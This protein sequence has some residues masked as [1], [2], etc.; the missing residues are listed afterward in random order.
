MPSY[1]NPGIYVTE[2]PFATNVST[3]PSTAAAAF[4]GT[5][6][7]GPTTPTLV[8]SWNSYKTMFGDLSANYELGYA[9]YHFFANGGRTAFVSRVASSAA[10][11]GFASFAGATGGSST[12]SL[13]KL[14]AN[15]AGAWGNKLK[16]SVSE[17]SVTSAESLT[18]TFNIV[19]KYNDTEVERWSELS[20]NKDDSRH[21]EAVINNY[22]S[23]I[24]SYDVNPSAAGASY[25][26][27]TVTD[28]ALTGGNDGNALTTSDWE[29]ALSGLD[30]VEGQ[31]TINLPGQYTPAIINKAIEYVDPSV[32]GVARKNSF[33]IIDPNPTKVSAEE[34]LSFVSGYTVS[35][36]AAVYYGMLLMSNPAVRGS[37]ALRSTFPGGAVAGLY[38]RVDTEK[39]VGR[40]PAGYSYTIQNAF[41]VITQFTEAQVGS[42]Y[43]PTSGPNVNTFK[44]VPGA[45]VIINGARTMKRTDITKY[46]PA[47]RTLNSIK[48][49][50][51]TL[52][53]PS[54]FQ[55][56][57]PRLW[58]SISGNLAR[59][60][61]NLWASGALKGKSASEAFYIIC[62]ESNNP[63]TA[64]EAGEVYVEIGVS[65]QAPAEFIIIN[66]SQFTGGSTVTET[67]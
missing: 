41:G 60:L 37:A 58:A 6:D 27:T 61:A 51:E 47:R 55:P 31:L 29:T 4:I 15:S 34:I 22:S 46:I 53:K 62:N 10:S 2:G 67:L 13:F 54:L 25:S 35:S 39:G 45:G 16:V 3:S 1:T 7:R 56:V 48:A 14:K 32:A 43:S 42:L 50:A 9:L 57:G 49:Q 23:Y 64:V 21:I 24:V 40:A 17:G 11:S 44:A 18:P 8:Q 26:V 30:K 33:L 20:L 63:V 12:A 52:T 38:Q 36:Y 5:A 65:L 66:I 19:V 59:M 28:T